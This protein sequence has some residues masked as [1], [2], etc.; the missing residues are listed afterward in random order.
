MSK[1]SRHNAVERLLAHLERS[2]LMECLELSD[3]DIADTIWLALQMGVGETTTENQ[4]PLPQQE[5]SQG[6]E[7]GKIIKAQSTPE[8]DST[9]N[10][11]SQDSITQEEPEKKTGANALPFQTPGAAALQNKLSISRALRPLMRKVPSAIK[12]I[13]DAEA[14]VTRI[15]ERDIWL[16]VTK[17]EPER[18]LSLELVVEESRALFIWTETI[19][20]LQKLLQSHG[21]FGAVRAWNLS[22][23]D[24][25]HLQLTR[26]RQGSQKSHY[27]H[28]YK[29]LISSNR[30]SLILLV[31][32]CVSNIWQQAKIHQWLQEWS[33]KALTAIVQLFPERLWQSTELG[34]GYKLQLSAFN[35]GVPN[36]NLVLPSLW[37]ELKGERVLKL[38]VV[39]LEAFS[40]KN[41]AKVIAGRGNTYTPGFVFELD[42]VAE[43]VQKS[44]TVKSQ[45]PS[46]ENLVDRFLATAS[47]TAQRLAGLMAAAPVS[48]PVINLIQEKLLKNKS[49]PVHV[50][51]VFLSGMIQ[52]T[53]TLDNG[54]NPKYDFV[55]EVR[56][57]L[58]QA[59][60]LG[61]TEN[62]LDVVSSYIAD[63]LG[64][65]IK[66]FTAL[67]LKYQDFSQ[68]QHEQILPFATVTIEV[69]KNLG[70][71]YADF[72][73]QVA[74]NI[75][76]SPLPDSESNTED[77]QIPELK[78]CTFK[79]AIVEIEETRT[80]EFYIATLERK[81]QLLGFGNRWV[82]N[83]QQ[84]QATSII[85]VLEGRIELELMEI[86]GGHFLMGSLEDEIGYSKTE[87]PQHTVTISPFRMG[88]Y[89]VTQA[90]WQAVAS[91]PQVNR[92]LNPN[93]SS[94]FK[95]DNLP[96]DTVS[97]YDAVE[98]CARLS[99][100]TN[101]PYRLPSEAE[102]EYACRAG[103]TTPFHFGETITSE[104]ANY[105]A[106][107]TYSTGSK[108]KYRASTTPVGSFKVANAFGLYDMHGNVW[109]W[110][111]DDWHENYEGAPT[112]GSAWL[113][114]KNNNLYQKKGVA[115]LRGG[116]WYDHPEACRCAS[117][118]IDNRVVRD[119]DISDNV[120]FRV[121]CA[122]GR[123]IE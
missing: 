16:P 51:E 46:P 42:F 8:A 50:A 9:I 32:D 30:R 23:T 18:W 123:I 1:V 55:P 82:I 80:S 19:D 102:W 88:K 14:T 44:A 24:N 122:F 81:S 63:N 31:S 121:V 7:D 76:V 21:A 28:S 27:Q 113:D 84:K 75:L 87:S 89:P 104:L 110:C 66:S 6:I 61:E 78:T 11:Y 68:E 12:T 36:S 94:R 10:I 96:V 79:V 114:S 49:T 39:T 2:G 98:F 93:P 72:A 117:R 26:R 37:E 90:Q 101:K 52:R 107:Y 35:P 40:L 100:Y 20:E 70:G 62:V 65:S 17:P 34:L 118:Y 92:E 97:W 119:D 15:A 112:D 105:N 111:L 106:N 47:L 54:E 86:P 48:L 67:L 5:T 77:E 22:S 120:G 60:R 45:E 95:G 57:L 41:W 29:E 53:N 56:K 4:Q 109:E 85:E 69:L 3:E 116:S 103:T 115:I 99:K 71:E 59:T 25:G 33:N 74:G 38:P 58:N 73:E 43:Q 83:R 64:L 91:L 13:L 108:G